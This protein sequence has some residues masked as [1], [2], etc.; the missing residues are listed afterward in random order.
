MRN[1]IS[2]LA[3]AVTLL[4]GSF[5]EVSA[6]DVDFGSAQYVNV[7]VADTMPFYVPNAFTPNNDGVNEY[8]M[9]KYELTPEETFATF[10][11]M[12]CDR[13]GNVLFKTYNPT[14]YWDG[15]DKNG[16]LCPAGVYSYVIKYKLRRNTKV[17]QVNKNDLEVRTGSVV[18][19]R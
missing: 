11:M 10:F 2:F 14:A 5:A 12:I 8:F 15:K 19:I 18:L 13:Y 6:H 16:V 17:E 3:V 4:L 7:M 1:S 9:L